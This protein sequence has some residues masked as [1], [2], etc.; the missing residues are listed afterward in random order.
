M[1]ISLAKRAAAYEAVAK[2]VIDYMPPDSGIT[3]QDVFEEVLRIV[4][5]TDAP[6]VSADQLDLPLAA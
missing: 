4:D 5:K 2:I 3:V 1:P 6:E